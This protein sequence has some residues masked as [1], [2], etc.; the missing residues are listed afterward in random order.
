MISDEELSKYLPQ[1]LSESSTI[2]LF[3]ELKQFPKNIDKRIYTDKLKNDSSIYQGDGLRNLLCVNLPSLDARPILGMIFS[4]TCD[5]NS[6]NKRLFDARLSYAP[7]FNL[8]KYHTALIQKY[9]DSS[10]RSSESIKSHVEDI[11]KQN[12]SQIFYLPKG[13]FLDNDSIVFLDRINNLPSNYFDGEQIKNNRAFSL[14]DYGFYIFLFKLS[15]HF[16][17]VRENVCRN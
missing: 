6:E 4:N 1:Y 10:E 15:I 2:S 17:R 7:I 12:I 13:G 5:I 9:V 14:S 16:T 11:K 3:N 8:E